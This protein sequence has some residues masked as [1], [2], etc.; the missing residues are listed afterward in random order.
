MKRS[1]K[2]NRK[3]KNTYSYLIWGADIVSDIELDLSDDKI[4]RKLIEAKVQVDMHN[5][6]TGS[7]VINSGKLRAYPLSD[8]N[9]LKEIIGKEYYETNW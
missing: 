4:K 1:R 7:F 6:V 5:L 3:E 8:H 9:K 2:I